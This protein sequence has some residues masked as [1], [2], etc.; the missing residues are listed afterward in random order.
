LSYLINVN[1]EE[2]EKL[3]KFQGDSAERERDLLIALSKLGPK[4][5]IITDGNN[6]ALHTIQ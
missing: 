3:T 2:A 1:R 6:G 4:I 5:C